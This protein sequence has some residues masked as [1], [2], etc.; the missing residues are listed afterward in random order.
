MMNSGIAV[1]ILVAFGDVE[2]CVP[3]GLTCVNVE[4]KLFVMSITPAIIA[5]LKSPAYGNGAMARSHVLEAR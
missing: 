4:T 2:I 3:L 1:T 5:A